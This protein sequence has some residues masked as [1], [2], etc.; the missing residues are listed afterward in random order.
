MSNI[1]VEL[2]L[3]VS[4]PITDYGSYDKCNMFNLDYTSMD[5]WIRPGEDTATVACTNWEYDE[6]LFQVHIRQC[7][8][9]SRT[10]ICWLFQ[11]T[12]IK[13]FDLVCDKKL[14]PRI[15]QMIFFAG[16]FVG[17]LASGVIGDKFGRKICY[18]IF[19]TLWIVFG[20]TGSFATNMYAWIISR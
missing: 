6:S 1:S 14:V 2:W 7:R 10:A 8:S 12:A 9:N 13:R 3:N 15:V 19:I 11:D 17:V 5:D 20:L 16:N 18:M 4:S